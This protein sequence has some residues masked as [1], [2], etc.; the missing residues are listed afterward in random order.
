MQIPPGWGQYFWVLPETKFR[1]PRVPGA[2]V[3]VLMMKTGT[4]P[5][6]MEITPEFLLGPQEP[7]SF[8]G[9][10][11]W[12]EVWGQRGLGTL[13]GHFGDFRISPPAGNS[14][15]PSPSGGFW[16]WDQR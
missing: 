2:F 7:N 16:F 6:T 14:P 9:G 4:V 12:R 5:L 15:L 13:W 10:L 1:P 8:H 11:G 3:L